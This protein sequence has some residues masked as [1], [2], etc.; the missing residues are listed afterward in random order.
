MGGTKL[1]N[2]ATFISALDTTTQTFSSID[3]PQPITVDTVIASNKITSLGSG[4]FQFEEDGIYKLVMFPILSKSSSG[5]M[6]HFLWIQQDVGAGFV[7]IADS[8]SETTLS[9]GDTGESKTI[10][11]VALLE[12]KKGDK[13]RFMNSVTDTNL[14]V[15]TKTPSA[16]QGPR[17][18]SIIM[19]INKIN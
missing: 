1:R 8:N 6:S 15:E 19:S 2:G 7:D 18:P 4:Q 5:V 10:T 17:I 3:T 16:G 12:F 13:I 9:S 14:D 11:F